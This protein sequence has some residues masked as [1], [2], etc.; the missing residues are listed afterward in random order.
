MKLEDLPLLK[1]KDIEALCIYFLKKKKKISQLR[2]NIQYDM[3]NK[4]FF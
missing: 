1:E 3:V 4:K 2:Y